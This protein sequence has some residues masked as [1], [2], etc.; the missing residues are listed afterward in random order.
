MDGLPAR[1]SLKHQ[2][3]GNVWNAGK[4]SACADSCASPGW[5]RAWIVPGSKA[6]VKRHATAAVTANWPTFFKGNVGVHVLVQG[7]LK[8]RVGRV[9]LALHARHPGFVLLLRRTQIAFIDD[10]HRL[11]ASRQCQPDDGR[12]LAPLLQESG[13]SV[14]PLAC[15]A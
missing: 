2:S 1:P 15:S 11:L 10:L 14:R 9:Q 4:A 5:F 13:M 6:C 7:G 3:C 12:G 8:R